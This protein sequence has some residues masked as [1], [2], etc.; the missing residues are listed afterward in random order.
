MTISIRHDT[1]AVTVH[2]FGPVAR[3]CRVSDRYADEHVFSKKFRI[4][5]AREIISV[6][7]GAVAAALRSAEVY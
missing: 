6:Q 1:L 7:A 4:L 2:I 5:P 3:G